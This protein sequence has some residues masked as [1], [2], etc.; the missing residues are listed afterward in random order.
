MR[1]LYMKI[2][3]LPERGNYMSN[4]NEA[5]IAVSKIIFVLRMLTE[6]IKLFLLML[7]VIIYYYI[8]DISELLAYRKKIESVQERKDKAQILQKSYQKHYS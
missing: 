2:Y 5:D 4:I 3:I 1:N 7:F 8:P 6:K